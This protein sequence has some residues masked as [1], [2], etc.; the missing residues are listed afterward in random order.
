MEPLVNKAFNGEI[1]EK[2]TGWAS[3][4]VDWLLDWAE[5]VIKVKNLQVSRFLLIKTQKFSLC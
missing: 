4:I 2:R 5:N 3:E 1:G